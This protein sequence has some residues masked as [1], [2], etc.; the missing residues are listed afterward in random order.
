M[1]LGLYL[2]YCLKHHCET[3]LYCLKHHCETLHYKNITKKIKSIAVEIY[4]SG[5][6][7]PPPPPKAEG[8][9]FVHVRPSVRQEPLLRN[10]ERNFMKLKLS[11][12][13]YKYV[14]HLK[15]SPAGLVSA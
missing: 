13:H 5:V 15:F 6:I 14:M 2:L 1:V 12:Y 3:L 11:M 8:Y 7:I 9:R 10:T 4:S